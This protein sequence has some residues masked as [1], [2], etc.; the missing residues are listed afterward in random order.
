MK[1]YADSIILKQAGTT[2]G[3]RILTFSYW[4]ENSF[5]LGFSYRNFKSLLIPG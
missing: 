2:E 5:T 3:L 4:P 1:K